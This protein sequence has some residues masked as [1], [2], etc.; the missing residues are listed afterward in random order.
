[1]LKINNLW[2]NIEIVPENYYK[3]YDYYNKEFTLG[4]CDNLNRVIYISKNLDK[5]TFKKVLHHE[6]IHA[7]IFSHNIQLTIE[8]EEKITNLIVTYG[9]KLT[10][11][12]NKIRDDYY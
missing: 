11:L 7:I 12:C 2:W 6:I 1:M 5:N 10:A 3:L 4:A 9:D 8:Q